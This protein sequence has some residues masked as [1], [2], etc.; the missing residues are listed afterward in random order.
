M[1]QVLAK[2]ENLQELSKG[3]LKKY[4]KAATKDKN[5]ANDDS[6]ISADKALA[7][8]KKSTEDK[9]RDDFVKHTNRYYKRKA[10]LYYIS[11]LS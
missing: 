10:G 2:E 5:K 1:F 4:I 11:R 9:Y 6:N 8:R 7:S 3:I